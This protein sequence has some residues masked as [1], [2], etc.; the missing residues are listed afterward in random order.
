[1]T[2]KATL[3]DNLSGHSLARFVTGS[4]G[5]ASAVVA[6]LSLCANPVL[7]FISH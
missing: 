2:S 5:I 6:R 3:R 1:M 7:I 4:A